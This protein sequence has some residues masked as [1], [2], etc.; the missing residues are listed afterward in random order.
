[1]DEV[2]APTV[3]KYFDHAEIKAHP[4]AAVCPRCG[5]DMLRKGIVDLVY[6][7]EVCRCDRVDYSHLMEQLWDRECFLAQAL[8]RVRA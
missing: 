5:A 6:T 4:A 3:A 2:R 7:F 8:D 1:M